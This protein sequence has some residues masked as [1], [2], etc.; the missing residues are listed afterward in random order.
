MK[1]SLFA[2]Y[3]FSYESKQPYI[4][5]TKW[6]RYIKIYQHP[7][8]SHIQ[9]GFFSWFSPVFSLKQIES[10]TR[11]GFHRCPWCSQRSRWTIAAWHWWHL[12]HLWHLTITTS[13]DS[14]DCLGWFGMVICYWYICYWSNFGMIW[15]WFGIAWNCSCRNWIYCGITLMNLA[16]NFASFQISVLPGWVKTGDPRSQ[17][18]WDLRAL[19]AVMIADL[20]RRKMYLTM[21]YIQCISPKR[22]S[23]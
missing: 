10:T 21:G 23:Q 6:L 16:I 1:H 11:S 20:W 15:N 8:S 9:G 13:M 18:L 7:T 22:Q 4:N 19:T 14:L 3:P 12:W 2:R 5:I 17:M